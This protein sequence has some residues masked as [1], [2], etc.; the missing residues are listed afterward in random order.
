M[1]EMT[2]AA[3]TG[4]YDP[5]ICDY[6][7]PIL[8]LLGAPSAIL[9]KVEKTCTNFGTCDA[10]IF[11]AEIPITALAGDQQ[12]SFFGCGCVELGDTKISLGT[13][14]FV[15]VNTGVKLHT[16]MEGQKNVGKFCREVKKNFQASFH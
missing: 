5:Y 14:S 4:M 3:C 13:G 15:E 7:Y 6:N 16:S 2:L 10:E 1:T 8:R 11:G 12:A 9:P